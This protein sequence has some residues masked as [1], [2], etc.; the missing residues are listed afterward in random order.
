MR[1]SIHPELQG[2]KLRVARIPTIPCM[3]QTDKCGTLGL[4]LK[5][6]ATS[7]Q[8]PYFVAT[9]ATGTTN[10][11]NRSMWYAYHLKALETYILTR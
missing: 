5:L 7:F 3:L 8:K 2:R 9:G 1:V 6:A 10:I 4:G 11:P